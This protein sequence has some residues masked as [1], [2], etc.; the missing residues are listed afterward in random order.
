MLFVLLMIATCLKSGHAQSL[1]YSSRVETLY[2]FVNDLQALDSI[3]NNDTLL[4]CHGLVEDEVV[5]IR[6]CKDENGIVDHIGYCFM[7][8]SLRIVNKSVVQFIERELLAIIVTTDAETALRS[9]LE[10]GLVIKFDGNPISHSL[11]QDK[12]KLCSLLKESDG[13]T[14]NRMNNNYDILIHCLN[15]QILSF[16][17]PADCRLISGMDKIEQEMRLGFQL[18]NHIANETDSSLLSPNESF[19]QF[20][21]DGVYYEK[22]EDFSIPQINSDLFYVKRD[23]VFC[24]VLDTSMVAM[25]FSNVMLVPLEMQFTF[26]VKHRMY[27]SVEQEYTINS[28]DFNDYF[29]QGYDRFFGIESLESENLSGTLMLYNRDEEFVHLVY[30]TTTK[31]DLFNGGRMSLELYSYIP[32]H[33]IK[34]LFGNE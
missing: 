31:E 22:G 15:G 18:K 6:I 10:N 32:Q 1:F 16:L 33:N 12:K 21:K 30:V 2:K 7:S 24:L 3:D 4:Q 25:S 29:S 26:D 14:V 17:F 20:L 27:G 9:D 19:L 5:P 8:D 11:L 34:T 28:R 13:V 23:S